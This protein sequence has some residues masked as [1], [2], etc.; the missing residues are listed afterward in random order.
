ME[1]LAWMILS[2]ILS[3]IIFNINHFLEE[4]IVM[5]KFKKKFLDTCFIIIL[6]LGLFLFAESIGRY[7]GR[8]VGPSI[9]L[10]LILTFLTGLRIS[11]KVSDI[12]KKIVA[13]IPEIAWVAFLLIG[14]WGEYRL[15]D[16]LDIFNAFEL[17]PYEKML[18]N[19]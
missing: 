8:Y 14:L 3:L 17:S 10:A 18:Q 6:C 1:I 13:S 4:K 16:K 9:T 2:I 11:A 15:A 12:G 19:R 7:D 5:E